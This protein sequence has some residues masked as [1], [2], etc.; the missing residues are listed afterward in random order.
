MFVF[1][2][3]VYV[4]LRRFPARSDCEASEIRKCLKSNVFIFYFLAR[5]HL[6]LTPSRPKCTTFWKCLR[7]NQNALKV[8]GEVPFLYDIKV[9][10]CFVTV[11]VSCMFLF[12]LFVM[13]A[14]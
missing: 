5:R 3:F 1:P 12:W 13:V 2:A 14:F 8:D 11:R 4:S 6:V 9:F 7:E 10:V